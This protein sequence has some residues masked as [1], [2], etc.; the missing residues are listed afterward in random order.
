[1]SKRRTNFIILV[2]WSDG[3]TEC[4]IYRE[5][6]WD[7]LFILENEVTLFGHSNITVEISV[8]G[9]FIFGLANIQFNN[10]K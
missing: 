1:M 4:T 6:L 7:N 8:G 5:A 2:L 9:A 3:Q 10:L